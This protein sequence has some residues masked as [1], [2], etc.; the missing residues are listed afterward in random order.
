METKVRV[1][2]EAAFGAALAAIAG[3]GTFGSVDEVQ[4]FIKYK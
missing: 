2:E 3:E 1:H 4:S